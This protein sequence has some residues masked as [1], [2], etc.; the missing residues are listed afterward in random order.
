MITG[1]AA[2]LFAKN[3]FVRRH[4]IIAQGEPLPKTRYS[5]HHFSR[6]A[7]GASMHSH[8]TWL[9]YYMGKKQ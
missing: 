2:S 7:R 1:S 5:G 3:G 9:A 8:R 6:L 4:E